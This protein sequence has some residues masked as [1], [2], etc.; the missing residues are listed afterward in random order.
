[1]KRYISS[2]EKRL[3]INESSEKKEE[4]RS[5][6]EDKSDAPM[7]IEENKLPVFFCLYPM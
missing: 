2:L 3:D 4:N 5:S 1:M 7:E 6:T